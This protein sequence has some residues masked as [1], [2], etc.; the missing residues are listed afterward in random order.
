[1]PENGF[2]RGFDK[3]SHSFEFLSG[4]ERPVLGFYALGDYCFLGEIENDVRRR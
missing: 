4:W 2:L 3:P 1:M